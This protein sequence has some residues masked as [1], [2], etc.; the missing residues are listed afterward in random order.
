MPFQP[1]GAHEALHRG[2]GN[3]SL[4]MTLGDQGTV[5][6]D[7][8][9][10]DPERRVV[11]SMNR[12]D[13]ILEDLIAPRP[14][15]GAGGSWPRRRSTGRILTP[16]L[17]STAQNGP[18]P[19][20]VLLGLHAAADQ[21]HGRAPAAKQTEALPRTAP[22]LRSPQTSNAGSLILPASLVVPHR[23]P[24]ST[25]PLTDPHTKGLRVDPQLV[26]D[27][28]DRTL[29]SGRLGQSLQRQP[30]RS[31]TKLN[32]VLP[33]PH[34]QRPFLSSPPPPNPER[35]RPSTNLPGQYN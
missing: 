25:S 35:N 27:P 32:Q 17:L 21:R 31:L 28:L 14:Q 5:R 20:L 2:A 16:A 13:L 8:P 3:M 12:A 33:P 4:S 24:R 30:R 1:H 19:E 11:L 29:R 26:G 9:L 23:V 18:G 22:A 7:V 10:A 6:H 34:A 15:S